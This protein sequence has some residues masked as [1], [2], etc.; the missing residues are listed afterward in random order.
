MFQTPFHG[1]ATQAPSSHNSS[2]PAPV[3]QRAGSTFGAFE[4][5]PPAVRDYLHEHTSDVC[6]IKTLEQW[7]DVQRAIRIVRDS[8]SKIDEDDVIRQFIAKLREAEENE[9]V[10]LA[11]RES[12]RWKAGYPHIEARATI[13]RYGTR[14]SSKTRRTLGTPARSRAR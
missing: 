3:S 11:H 9:I 12:A 1:W 6:P 5:L 13:Q 4:Q 8:G 14:A 7:R 10:M 2:S